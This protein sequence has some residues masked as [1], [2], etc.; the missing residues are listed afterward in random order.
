MWRLE[1]DFIIRQFTITIT[2]AS[3]HH[4]SSSVTQAEPTSSNTGEV[5][6]ASLDNLLASCSPL[7]RV[8]LQHDGLVCLG[9]A[10]PVSGVQS[11]RR[12]KKA[13]WVGETGTYG[14]LWSA[15]EWLCTS[16]SRGRGQHSDLD[17]VRWDTL[18]SECMCIYF[19][20]TCVRLFHLCIGI[21][22]LLFFCFLNATTLQ[23]QT[24]M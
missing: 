3:T 1:S 24:V 16:G 11:R 21:F 4:C 7:V 2:E 10:E 14:Q 9:A 23:R 19:F 17:S 22:M 20:N 18:L 6:V 13:A 8:M 12:K 5:V 15:S